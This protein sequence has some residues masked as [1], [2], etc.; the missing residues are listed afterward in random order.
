MKAKIHPE[1]GKCVVTCSCGN[2]FI[3]GSTRKKIQVEICSAC[4]PF[5]TGKKKLIDDTGRVKR[6]EKIIAKTKEM[7]EAKT[8]KI[9]RGKPRK[10]FSRL[11]GKK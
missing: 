3:T 6:F 9:R 5:Y 11:P 10:T 7:K 2:I 1:Y 4:H 8:K